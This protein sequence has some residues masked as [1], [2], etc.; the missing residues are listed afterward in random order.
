[1]QRW[2]RGGDLTSGDSATRVRHVQQQRATTMVSKAGTSK[3]VPRQRRRPTNRGGGCIARG[4]RCNEERRTVAGAAQGRGS[5]DRRAFHASDKERRKTAGDAQPP[6]VE[7]QGRR[8]WF[9][10]RRPTA[11]A[12]QAG[13]VVGTTSGRCNVHSQRRQRP[14]LWQTAAISRFGRQILGRERLGVDGESFE[15][16]DG[17]ERERQ[18]RERVVRMAG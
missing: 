10:T 15:R 7:G 12:A 18:G 9:P 16:V 1:M 4:G 6:A 2:F 5:D 8:P 13:T 14:Q 11:G 3:S 17:R